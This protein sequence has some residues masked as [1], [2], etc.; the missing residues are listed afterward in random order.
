[1]RIFENCLEAINE[2][3]RDVFSRGLIVFDQT[4]QA[5]IVTKEEYDS[6]ELIGYGYILKS[7][8]DK[9]EMLNWARNTFNK[10]HLTPEYAEAWFQDMIRGTPDNPDPSWTFWPE[11]WTQ[12]MDSNKKLSYAYAERMSSTLPNVIDAL[13]KSRYRRGATIPIFTPI[14][15]NRIGKERI[16]CSISYS[17]YVRPGTFYDLLTL[18]YFMRSSDLC[19]FFPI[20]VYRALRLKEYV[21]E[22]LKV[23][24]GDLI[25]FIGS[26]HAFRKDVPKDRQW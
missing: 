21:A 20:D 25:H 4:V 1:M 26:L 5:K 3:T 10:P 13:K 12:F 16:P 6:K 8:C 17:F 14:D 23:V 15:T 9:N 2:I 24:P 18:V 19:N 22:E 7:G 11:Y